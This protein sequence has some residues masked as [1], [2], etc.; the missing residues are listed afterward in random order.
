MDND[1]IAKETAEIARLEA[2]STEGMDRTAYLL[3]CIVIK[4]AYWRLRMASRLPKEVESG[5]CAP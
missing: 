2:L 5:V 3:H 1:K 4:D